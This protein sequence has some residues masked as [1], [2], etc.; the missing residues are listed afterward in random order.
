MKEFHPFQLD[1][2]NQCLWRVQTAQNE[3]VQLTP[4]GFQLLRHLVEHAG[5]LVTHEEVI[6]SVWSRT[7][8]EP[9]VLKQHVCEIRKVLG[10]RAKQPRFIETHPRR[11]YRFIAPVKDS[12]FLENTTAPGDPVA[13]TLVG[14]DM[15]LT[16][17]QDC[18]RRVMRGQRQIV[19][20]TGEPGIGKTALA[21]KFQ[22]LAAAEVASLRIGRGQC[23]E[24]YGGIE[25]YYPV[26]EALTQ[27]CRGTSGAA[28][29]QTLAAPAPTWLVQLPTLLNGAQCKPFRHEIVGGTPSRMLREISE[30]LEVITTEVPL[31]LV[32]EDLHWADHATVDLISALARRRAPAKLLV[33]ATTRT[34]GMDSHE[35]PMNLVKNE[36][37][38]HRLCRA[39]ELTPLAETDVAEYLVGQST[40]KDLPAGLSALVHRHCDGNPLF[41]V[42]AI[43]HLTKR[44]LITCDTGR[45]EL[46]VALETI[47]LEV[48]DSLGQM[49]EVRIARLSQEEQRVLEAA[50]I[51]GTTF[52]PGVN[53]AGT[54]LRQASFEE[55]CETLARR[56][57]IVRSVGTRQFPNTAISSRYEF[58][59]AMYREVLY[60]RQAP[61]RRATLHR[62]VGRRLEELFADRVG[63]VAAELAWHFE[64]GFDYGRAKRYQRLTTEGAAH[65]DVYIAGLELHSEPWA[66]GECRGRRV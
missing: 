33:I 54:N 46:R 63:D 14:R 39:I 30:A 38:M 9:E 60:L 1:V 17:L 61:G 5:R 40:T 20:V 35:H 50:S 29:L 62:R 48:P 59:H 66:I 58:A 4:K 23:I 18:L 27:L 51:T 22:R 45:W 13:Q 11:G 25:A 41:M 57:A 10:D 8:V 37:L 52:S 55:I 49:I 36:L 24:G 32:F 2:V 7:C 42:A 43:E 44:G 26:L 15:A 16:E 28:L 56:H 3:R 65:G 12:V 6:R 21:D 47:D 64:Q 34:T 19:F 53:A 31:L